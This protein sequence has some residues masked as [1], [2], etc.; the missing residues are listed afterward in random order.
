MWHLGRENDNLHFGEGSL[1]MMERYD[2]LRLEFMLMVVNTKRFDI[3][4]VP[5]ITECK[6]DD[7]LVSLYEE[8]D[9]L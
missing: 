9:Q 3:F 1:Y 6:S 5:L 2:Y 7:T 4:I 8:V